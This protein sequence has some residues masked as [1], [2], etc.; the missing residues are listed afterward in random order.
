MSKTQ[1]QCRNCG[2]RISRGKYCSNK[3]QGDFTHKEFIASWLAGTNP[4]AAHKGVNKYASRHIYRWFKD[5][6]KACQICGVQDWMGKPLTLQLDH[7]S[8]DRSDA[9]RDNLRLICPNCHSQTDTYAG[10]SY[11]KNMGK[12]AQN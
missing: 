2:K 1:K 11:G 7:I 4:N 9:G 10:K 6:F 12:T 5:N 8:G 3:C